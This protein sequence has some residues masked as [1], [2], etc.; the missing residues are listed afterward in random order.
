MQGLVG[1]LEAKDG[2]EE[3]LDRARLDLMYAQGRLGRAKRYAEEETRSVRAELQVIAIGDI[4][5][6][7][8]PGEV[9]TEIGTALKS[10]SPFAHTWI[11]GYAN[12]S[13]G[14]FPTP[15]EMRKGGY[16]ALVSP[17]SAEAIEQMMH[18]A[19]ALL[20]RAREQIGD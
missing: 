15:E 11:V 16:E 17:F 19:R 4:A 12:D 9:F 18:A 6:L 13:I 7:A 1:E 5:L 3:A 8:M 20:R 2:P 14:Y 10:D